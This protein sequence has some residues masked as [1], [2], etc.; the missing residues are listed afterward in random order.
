[1]LYTSSPPSKRPILSNTTHNTPL[2]ARLDC[3]LILPAT[4]SRVRS[5]SDITM[6]ALISPMI[7]LTLGNCQ[8]IHQRVPS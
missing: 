5:R 1:M 7:G 8:I 3:T 6:T 4:V 2:L